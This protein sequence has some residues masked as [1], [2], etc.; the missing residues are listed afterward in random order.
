MH[1]DR[2]EC[3]QFLANPAAGAPPHRTFAVPQFSANG[4]HF[5][6]AED[7]EAGSASRACPFLIGGTARPRTRQR[8]IGPTPGQPGPVAP[9]RPPSGTMPPPSYPIAA[10]RLCRTPPPPPRMVTTR[11]A[12]VSMNTRSW[13]GPGGAALCGGPGGARGALRRT[14]DE[15]DHLSYPA[16]REVGA[17]HFDRTPDSP[18]RV[19]LLDLLCEVLADADGDQLARA[20]PASPRI[21]G[22]HQR[23]RVGIDVSAGPGAAVAREPERAAACQAGAGANVSSIVKARH[24]PDTS[25]PA[26]T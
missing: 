20:R 22:G 19:G 14:D 18:A 9:P 24:P 6:S 2:T 4:R 7:A 26:P 8:L 3:S 25:V 13:I 12:R 10:K 17:R 21:C 16:G 15:R 11:I 5:L 1:H 23:P